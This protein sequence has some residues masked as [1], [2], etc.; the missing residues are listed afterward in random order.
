MFGLTFAAPL[1]LAALIG[2]PA[3]WILLRVT[4]P[5]PRRI[6][7]PPLKLVADLIPQRQTPARTPPWL[8]ILRLLLA[9]ALILAVA[10]PVWSP[11]GIG[12]GGGK[13]PLLVLIDNG[14]AAAHDWRD[15]LRVAFARLSFDTISRD[16]SAGR[17]LSE[18]RWRL[19]SLI[20]ARKGLNIFGATDDCGPAGADCLGEGDVPPSRIEG[21]ADAAVCASLFQ[22][23]AM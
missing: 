3:L 6:D 20:E 2:L 18:P 12:A 23:R 8:L 9:A 19:S 5:R 1:A 15:R 10:G 17:S 7:F 11:G 21:Q 22:L 13:K 14:F 4:P 16:F